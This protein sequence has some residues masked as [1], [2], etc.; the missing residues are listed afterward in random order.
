MKKG[1]ILGGERENE[2]KNEWEN[3]WDIDFNNYFIHCFCFP[4]NNYIYYF[5]VG[6]VFPVAVHWGQG[7]G[8]LAEGIDFSHN[9]VDYTATY[10]VK[11][12]HLK[13]RELELPLFRVH[14]MLGFPVCCKFYFWCVLG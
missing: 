7:E 6:F 11:C 2:S 3:E 4:F 10:E 14:Y 13:Q 8:W 5:V 1:I 9:N 12:I